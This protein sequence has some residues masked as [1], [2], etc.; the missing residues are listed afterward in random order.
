MPPKQN[1]NR[2][3]V[4]ELSSAEEG[5]DTHMQHFGK[6]N[7]KPNDK[8]KQNNARRNE[9]IGI[10]QRNTVVEPSFSFRGPL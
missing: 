4:S 9:E 8:T 2:N 7:G 10:E 3:A 5:I 6:Q 1:G